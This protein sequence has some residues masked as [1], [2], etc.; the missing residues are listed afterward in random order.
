[1]QIENSKRY[2]FFL[3]G[4]GPKAVLLIHGITGTPSEMRYLGKSLNKAGYTVFCNTLPRHCD[5]LGELKKVTWEEIANACFEDLQRLKKEYAQVF[6]GGLSMGALLAVHLA[7]KF[8]QDVTGIIALAPTLFYDGW[9]LHK[10]KIFLN[11]VW[12][13][14][15]FRNALDIRESWP[16]GLKDEDLRW[17]IERFYKNASSREFSKKVLLFGSPFFP[18]A[19]LYQ[20]RRFTEVVKKEMPL[21]KNPI[22]ILH[23]EEDDMT[24]PKNA[25]YVLEHIGSADKALVI[26]DDS[27]HMIVIDKQKDKVAGEVIKFLNKF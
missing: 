25:R 23:A 2:T 8:P 27:Y 4:N 6:V 18:A 17:S 11:L 12:P 10:G 7:Y 20:H 24:S 22:L 21:V 26:L 5:T 13:V 19:C 16:Y 3:K 14:P 1:M 15:F 9:A